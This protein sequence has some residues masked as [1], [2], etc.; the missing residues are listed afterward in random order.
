MFYVSH[1]FSFLFHIALWVNRPYF[2]VDQREE[3]L[4]ASAK[5]LVY[6]KETWKQKQNLSSTPH[7]IYSDGEYSILEDDFFIQKKYEAMEYSSTHTHTQMALGLRE[8]STYPWKGVKF[9]RYR[10]ESERAGCAVF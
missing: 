4:G 7:L 1:F 9:S 10:K 5:F 6:G 8:C 3:P 2:F